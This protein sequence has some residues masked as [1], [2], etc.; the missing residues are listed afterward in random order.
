MERRGEEN[1]RLELLVASS[2]VMFVVRTHAPNITFIATKKKIQSV[3]FQ[4]GPP[5]PPL[6]LD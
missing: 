6:Q 5:S 4:H 2:C 3:C 1:G